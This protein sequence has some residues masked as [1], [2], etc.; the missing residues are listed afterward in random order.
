M[1]TAGRERGTGRIDQGRRLG[2]SVAAQGLSSGSNMALQYGM[3]VALPVDR[4]GIFVVGAS[5]YYL[6]LALG[7]AWIGDPLAAL[8]DRGRGGTLP[9][10]R[11]AWPAV[12]R[13]AAGLGMVASAL[14][15]VFTAGVAATAG[16]GWLE[17]ASLGVGLPVL[18]VQDAG[19][20]Q[21]WATHRPR[22]VAL[23]DGLWLVVEGVTGV[24]WLAAWWITGAVPAGLAVMWSWLAGGLVSAV[25]VDRWAGRDWTFPRSERQRSRSD[26]GEVGDRPL[27][28]SAT[29]AGVGAGNPGHRP[30]GPATADEERLV[31]RSMGLSQTVL[32]VD[33]NLWPSVV[34]A[35]TAP[36]VTATMRTAQVPFVPVGSVLGAM[37]VLTLPGLRRAV[38]GGHVRATVARV[39]ALD[40]AVALALVAAT[41]VGVRLLP[42]ALLG[43]AG[44]LARPWYPLAGVILT[45]RMLTMPLTDVLSLGAGRAG[46]MRQRLLSTGVDLAAT[47]AGAALWGP[48]GALAAKATAGVVTLLGWGTAVAVATSGSGPDRPVGSD[49]WSA[50]LPPDPSPTPPVP[51]SSRTPTVG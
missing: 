24:A 50:A 18:L 4:F 39:V 43:E 35:V 15:G 49:S 40:G 11:W 44:R 37:R 34:A 16:V 27:A 31:T 20:Y 3:L 28:G 30:E 5:G 33:A 23:A 7:R 32:A 21:L 1:T 48:G 2:W 41:L 36:S 6:A 26:P 10:G 51:T 14:L 42:P 38:V 25:V 19:R 17:L 29:P 45:A 9:A 46:V 8:G 12:R 22:Q 47:V 13:R